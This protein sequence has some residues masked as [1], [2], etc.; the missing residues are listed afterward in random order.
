MA[1][2]L[3]EVGVEAAKSAGLNYVNDH[4]PGIRR[5]IDGRG[6]DYVD[7]DGSAVRDEA[8]LAR[9]RRLAIPPAWTDVWISPDPNGHIQAV[10]RDARGRKQYRYHPEWRAVRDAQ[11]Y[12]RLA[13]FGR[14]L[15]KLR[16]R[17][18]ADLVLP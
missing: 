16:A 1:R 15:P 12:A 3:A 18:E 10:G 14:A 5:T 8:T 13:A 6:V 4:D 7:S 2:D 17:I 9:I 11:K